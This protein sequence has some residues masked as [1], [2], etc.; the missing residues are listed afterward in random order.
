[1]SHILIVSVLFHLNIFKYLLQSIKLVFLDFLVFMT[2]KL[3]LCG[4]YLWICIILG[5]NTEILKI[6]I[7]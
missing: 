6:F 2:P 3:F 5:T 7:Y 4:L 1:M